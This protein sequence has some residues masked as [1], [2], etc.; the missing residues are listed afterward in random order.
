MLLTSH[1]QDLPVRELNVSGF[2]FKVT[3]FW[4]IAS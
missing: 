2:D 3:K 4:Y 1:I